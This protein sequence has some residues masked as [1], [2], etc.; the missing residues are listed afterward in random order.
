MEHTEFA[1]NENHLDLICFGVVTNLGCEHANASLS[2]ILLFG[3]QRVPT[4][5]FA[6]YDAQRVGFPYFLASSFCTS[7][8]LLANTS[9]SE[10]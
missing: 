6:S 1:Q 3:V 7:F 2:L 5:L 4:L 8:N 10:K 9:A